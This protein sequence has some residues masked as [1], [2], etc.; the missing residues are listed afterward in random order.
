MTVLPLPI[1]LYVTHN[2]GNGR[3]RGVKNALQ[4]T[5]T[6]TRN[7]FLVLV[8]R[9]ASPRSIHDAA[10]KAVAAISSSVVA[11]RRAAFNEEVTKEA[12]PSLGTCAATFSAVGAVAGSAIFAASTPVP[13]EKAASVVHGHPNPEPALERALKP[14]PTTDAKPSLCT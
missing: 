2:V 10:T 8:K 9:N 12:L 13:D 11:A 14:S 5:P 4:N 1:P 3:S 7:P 6:T